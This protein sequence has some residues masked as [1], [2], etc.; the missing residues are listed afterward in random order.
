VRAP[1]RVAAPATPPLPPRRRTARLLAA[2]L[3]AAVP[4]AAL[5]AGPGRPRGAAAGTAPT[6]DTFERIWRLADLPPEHERWAAAVGSGPWA[7]PSP[8]PTGDG[9]DGETGR[10]HV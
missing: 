1:H 4:D 7:R 6:T 8:E 2:A 10:A 9:G 5:P 3:L